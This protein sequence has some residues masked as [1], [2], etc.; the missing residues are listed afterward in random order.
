M[1]RAM[2]GFSL[3]ALLG[4][5]TTKSFL[6]EAVA[7]LQ[8]THETGEG[9]VTIGIDLGDR[10]SYCCVLSEEANVL[11][12]GRIR[13]NAATL[14]KFFEEI[15]PCRI[16][17]E[18]GTH[19]RWVYELLSS[20][21]HEVIV[22]NTGAIQIISSN[23]RKSDEVDAQM[24]ARLA[25]AD[26][27]LLS[28]IQHRSGSSYEDVV[29]LNARDLLVRT[30]VKLINA[31]RGMV[32]SSGGRLPTS[33]T[34]YFVGKAA[35][36]VPE[37]LRPALTP[38][39][40]NIARLTEQIREFDKRIELIARTRYPETARLRQIN[41]VGPLTALKFVLT[42]GDP[43]RFRQSRDVGPYLGLV[44]R[45]HQSGS[46]DKQMRISKAG[47][48]QLRVL[49]V[50]CAQRMLSRFGQ[51]S[52]LKRWGMRMASRG[53][54]SS[55][56]RAVTAVARKLAVLLHRLWVSADV[57]RPLFNAMCNQGLPQP[58]A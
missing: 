35:P 2:T 7:D 21:G 38:L 34:E 42:I 6:L 32:K 8:D 20:W 37:A 10:Y 55:K 53:G 5:P 41:G 30:R 39:I 56:K 52:D 24:L 23:N 48:R 47:N 44:P 4:R 15:P 31:V 19:S 26:P 29:C 3:T 13:T 11:A 43:H 9:N 28:P 36:H 1:F 51:D 27:K 17:I 25:R 22:A 14:K 58:I 40:E 16:A 45:R 46:V 54:K 18:A 33:T 50:Q 49:L 57:Y 12:Q